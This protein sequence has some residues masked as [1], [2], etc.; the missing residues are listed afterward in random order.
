MAG[1][2]THFLFVRSNFNTWA[3]TAAFWTH[4]EIKLTGCDVGNV[5]VQRYH[6][7]ILVTCTA[8]RRIFYAFPWFLSAV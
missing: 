4:S 6:S 2:E 7:A 3:G 8:F 1:F 5:D